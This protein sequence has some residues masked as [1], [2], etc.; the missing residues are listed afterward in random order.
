IEELQTG[1]DGWRLRGHR[2]SGAVRA[3]MK[4]ASC[5]LQ[6]RGTDGGGALRPKTRPAERQLKADL[7]LLPEQK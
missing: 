7:I 2:S 6:V 4:R 5:R 1:R 3:H